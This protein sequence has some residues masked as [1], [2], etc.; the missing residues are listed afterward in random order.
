MH[1][2]QAAAEYSSSCSGVLSIGASHSH[3]PGQTSLC[4]SCLCPHSSCQ[5]H[6]ARKCHT[7]YKASEGLGHGSFTHLYN[8]VWNWLAKVSYEP[9]VRCF[10][11]MH[12]L[13]SQRICLLRE[14]AEFF[15]T[16]V[17]VHIVWSFDSYTLSAEILGSI[18]Y[19]FFHPQWSF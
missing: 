11:F 7:T 15:I 9:L 19:L 8:G 13:F 18:T 3:C 14:H 17:S 12:A 5:L 16:V 4:H 6:R 10:N 1:S 2:Y